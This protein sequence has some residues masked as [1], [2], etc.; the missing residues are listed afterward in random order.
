MPHPTHLGGFPLWETTK[1]T[2]GPK[3]VERP[4]SART[5]CGRLAD[6]TLVQLLLSARKAAERDG[7]RLT[8]AVPASGALLDA[9]TRG[10]VL[11]AAD[12][13]WL[14]PGVSK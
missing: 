1:N 11:A 9:L 12:P 5:P 3:V 10:G 14:Q 4:W 2:S 8:L 13:F 7:K 6:L